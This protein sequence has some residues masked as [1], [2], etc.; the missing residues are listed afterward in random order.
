MGTTMSESIIEC[1]TVETIMMMKLNVNN[2][3]A[4]HEDNNKRLQ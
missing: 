1:G 3:K 4:I 2:V